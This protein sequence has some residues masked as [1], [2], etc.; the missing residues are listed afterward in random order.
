MAS[1][2]E[3]ELRES[4]TRDYFGFLNWLVFG[5]FMAKGV[6]NLFDKNRSNLFNIKK[7]GKGIKHWLNDIS[8]K[9]HAEIVAKGGNNVRKNIRNLN[10]A[11]VSGLLYSAITLGYL[12]PMINDKLTKARAK[13]QN[14]P[15][16]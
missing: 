10:L 9:T 14:K 5:G 12:L 6:A 1:D 3:T 8:L 13:K 2:N 11:H 4:V 15:L 16:A 7:E